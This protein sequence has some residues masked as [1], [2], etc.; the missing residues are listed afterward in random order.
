MSGKHI[1]AARKKEVYNVFV[2]EGIEEA[3]NHGRRIGISQ[4]TVYRIC[5]SEDGEFED[6]EYLGRAPAWDETQKESLYDHV[7][8]NPTLTLE[9]L[10]VW[11]LTRNFPSVTAQTIASYL[12][13]ELF[14]Y[15]QVTLSP[16]AR[17]SP[18][19]KQDR[20]DF[21]MWF[22]SVDITRLVF[23]DET[24][25]CLCVVRRG[26]HPPGSD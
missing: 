15:L 14:T 18:Q 26:H 2:A 11:G 8:K 19:V 6:P 3:L 9:E 7:E 25:I 10:R 4:S 20:A 5:G 21:S 12:D 22:L 24:G 17:N 13:K 16:T 1:G 23:I